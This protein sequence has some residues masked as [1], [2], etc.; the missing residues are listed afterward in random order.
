MEGL[1]DLSKL[2]ADSFYVSI[3]TKIELLGKKDITSEEVLRVQQRL[4]DLHVIKL[5]TNIENMAIKIKQQ[6][7]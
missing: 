6:R 5:D 7:S 3:I 1:F 2:Q 4:L